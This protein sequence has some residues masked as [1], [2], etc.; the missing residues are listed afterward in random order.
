ML[1]GLPQSIAFF[2]NTLPVARCFP[3]ARP[4]HQEELG[5]EHSMNRRPYSQHR[6]VRGEAAMP[7]DMQP[8]PFEGK[9]SYQGRRR[10]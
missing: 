10:D 4:C 3:Y 7:V 8:A 6:V 1:A 5:K 9:W 2:E